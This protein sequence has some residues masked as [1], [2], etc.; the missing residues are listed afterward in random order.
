[1]ADSVQISAAD[2]IFCV[3]DFDTYRDTPFNGANLRP[4]F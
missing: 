3:V 2:F 4:F 1:M